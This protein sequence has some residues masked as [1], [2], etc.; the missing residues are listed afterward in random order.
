MAKDD[1]TLLELTAAQAR[2]TFRGRLDNGGITW[3]ATVVALGAHAETVFIDVGKP[4][5]G[6][7]PIRIGLS[8][9]ALDKPTLKKT[10]VMVRQ[11]Q[12]LRRGRMEYPNP[13]RAAS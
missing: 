4:A 5:A 12:R 13:R 6:T 1:Y 3:Q 8:V 9:D 11:Y 2:L 10:V 7:A